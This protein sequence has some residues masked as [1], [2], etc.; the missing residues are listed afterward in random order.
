MSTTHDNAGQQ[1]A[2]SHMALWDRVKTTPESATKEATV[3][4]QKIRAIDTVHMI[5]MATREFGPM[6]IGWGYSIDDERFDQGAPVIDEKGALIGHEQTHTIRMTLWFMHDNQ[7]GEVTQYGHTR[8]IYRTTMGKWITD[9][10]APKKSTSDAMKKCLSLLGF[11]ADV[12]SGLYDDTGYVEARKTEERLEKSEDL[13]AELDRLRQEFK[14]W[15]GNQSEMLREKIPHPRSIAMAA[16]KALSQL[17]DR[18]RVAR[19]DDHTR[20]IVRKQ[21][22]DAAK[23]GTERVVSEREEA[24]RVA[25]TNQPEEATNG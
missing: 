8:A 13:D 4:G 16:D 22:E 7:R 9:G 19:V 14:T 12:F 17:D 2:G 1:Q 3:G 10:E 11:A 21:I 6:G 5:R 24:K 18:A 15:A 25:Q 23:Y 20:Q